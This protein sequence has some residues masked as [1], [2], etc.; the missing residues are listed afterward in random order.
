MACVVAY[1]PVGLIG[2]QVQGRNDLTDCNMRQRKN[3]SRRVPDCVSELDGLNGRQTIFEQ[4]KEKGVCL[5]FLSPP[6]SSL[7]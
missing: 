7:A 3:T 6:L 4:G 2:T 1:W 5:G